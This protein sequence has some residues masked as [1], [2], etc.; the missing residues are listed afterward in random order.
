MPIRA[1]F[2]RPGG[3][4]RPASTAGIVKR[5]SPN[6]VAV[7]ISDTAV[8][9]VAAAAGSAP[10]S[11]SI[12]YWSAPPAAAPPGTMREKA[13]DASWE[14]ISA[15]TLQSRKTSVCRYQTQAKLASSAP[16]ITANHHGANDVR[17]GHASKT[18]SR[19]GA[20]T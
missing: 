19:L 12:R 9:P 4:A 14:V 15:K 11:D 6:T 17:R 5:G 3:T 18:S 1:A 13:F 16:S 10:D 2:S 8:R 7:V 20:R